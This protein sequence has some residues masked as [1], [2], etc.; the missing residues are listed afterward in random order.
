MAQRGTQHLGI[1]HAGRIVFAI[2]IA[3]ASA[4]APAQET[5]MAHGGTASPTAGPVGPAA[6]AQRSY[7]AVKANILKAANNMPADAYP[8]KPTPDIR[9]FARVI[10][11][12]SEAQ[13]RSCGA[14]NGTAAAAM[15]SMPPE[16]ADKTVI[17]TAL[18]AS[19]T[20]C[21]AAFAALTDTNVSDM[22]TAGPGRRSRIGL[23]WGTVSHDN[24]QYATLA[25]YMRLKGLAP[26]SSEK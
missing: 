14:A 9:T 19:F 10:N 22:L 21:D 25:L 26:P 3:L 11:H 17:V 18:Q 24:E 7:A 20:A 2:G 15:P 23:L 1:R 8:F 6:E 16:T 5:H 13:E 4:A 12:V